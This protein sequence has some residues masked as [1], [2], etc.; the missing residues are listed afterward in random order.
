MTAF[1]SA[2]VAGRAYFSSAMPGFPDGDHRVDHTFH[3]VPIGLFMGFVAKHAARK[4]ESGLHFLHFGIEQ[5]ALFQQSAIRVKSDVAFL[6]VTG[7][8]HRIPPLRSVCAGRSC[9]ACP[10]MISRSEE[11]RVGKECRSRWSPY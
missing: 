7:D 11:R 8:S 4:A 10:M 3:H 9:S 1:R 6:A 5:R 2:I